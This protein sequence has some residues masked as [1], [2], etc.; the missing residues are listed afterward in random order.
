MRLT[1]NVLRWLAQD[2]SD[3][4]RECSELSVFYDTIM[5]AVFQGKTECVV[6]FPEEQLD[7]LVERFRKF[8]F[9][10]VVHKYDRKWDY[11]SFFPKMYCTPVALYWFSSKDLDG[12]VKTYTE[13]PYNKDR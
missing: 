6:W 1:A 10:I 8:G 11:R 9:D 12:T 3:M 2:I 5:V 13:N 4:N 7:H